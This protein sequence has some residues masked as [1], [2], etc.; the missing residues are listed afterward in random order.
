VLRARDEDAARARFPCPEEYTDQTA[1][2]AWTAQ[3]RH[4]SP[5]AITSPRS[6]S[7]STTVAVVAAADRGN[8][9]F[10]VGASRG[11]PFAMTTSTRCRP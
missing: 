2:M 1:P 5:G 11:R 9:P 4:R 3:Q 10:C 8:A 7:D 6:S